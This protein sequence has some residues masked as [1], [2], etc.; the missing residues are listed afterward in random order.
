MLI[1]A[2]NKK[3]AKPDCAYLGGQIQETRKRQPALV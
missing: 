2:A 1:L 3:K